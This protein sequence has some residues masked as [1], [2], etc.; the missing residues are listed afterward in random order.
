MD[1][2]K[3]RREIGALCPTCGASHFKFDQ[4]ADET[5]EMVECAACGRKMTKDELLF[6]NSENIAEHVNEIGQEAVK[7]IAKEF[8]RS[9]KRSFS[10]SKY[11]KIK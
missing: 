10:G 2:E 3:Y 7:D 9:L 1:S 8:K 4:G 5:I 11:I 6:E